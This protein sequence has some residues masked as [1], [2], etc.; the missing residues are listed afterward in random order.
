MKD[1]CFYLEFPSKQAR[2]KSGKENTGHAGNVFAGFIGNP[3]T[4]SGGVEG[5][6]AVHDFPDSPVA[7]TQAGPG[8][9]RQCKRIPEALARE[10]H[11]RLFERLDEKDEKDTKS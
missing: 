11:P 10:I 2:K 4:Q 7:S 8:F 5:L 9:L 3:R 1:V 6:G